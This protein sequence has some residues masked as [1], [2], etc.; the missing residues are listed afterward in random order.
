MIV[1]RCSSR[2]YWDLGDGCAKDGMSGGDK[3]RPV[4]QVH[5]PIVH[6]ELLKSVF[7]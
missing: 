4:K 6:L 7:R 2:H 1:L 5:R 3:K